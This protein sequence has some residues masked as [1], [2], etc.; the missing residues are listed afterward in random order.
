LT[1][2]Q[3]LSV[4]QLVKS[5]KGNDVWDVAEL[6]LVENQLQVSIGVPEEIQSILY[7]FVEVFQ[8]P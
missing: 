3:A 7:E 5:Y 2:I 8:T 6:Y 4:D 1:S